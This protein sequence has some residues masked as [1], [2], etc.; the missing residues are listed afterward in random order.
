MA[1]IWISGPASP[2]G[3]NTGGNEVS[4]TQIFN[5]LIDLNDNYITIS[6]PVSPCNISKCVRFP[7][8]S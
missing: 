7:L 6:P 3:D 2:A 8:C 4:S 1:L 5:I